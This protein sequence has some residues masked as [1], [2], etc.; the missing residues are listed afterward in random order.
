MEQCPLMQGKLSAEE[1][2]KGVLQRRWLSGPTVCQSVI[3]QSLK[4]QK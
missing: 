4:I 2:A 3:E 1:L